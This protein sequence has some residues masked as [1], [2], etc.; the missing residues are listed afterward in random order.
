MPWNESHLD[1]RSDHLDPST[2][3]RDSIRTI[4]ISEADG[5]EAVVG[6]PPARDYELT[7]SFL[8]AKAKG[9]TMQKAQD[10][11]KEHEHVDVPLGYWS[12]GGSAALNPGGRHFDSM[13][14]TVGDLVNVN[15]KIDASQERS[16]PIQVSGCNSECRRLHRLHSAI[17]FPC[18]KILCSLAGGPLAIVNANGTAR[19]D[20]MRPTV[21]D[22]VD[23]TVE[24]AENS[25]PVTR[26]INGKLDLSQPT[27][28]DLS[29]RG[30]GHTSRGLSGDIG[31]HPRR[32]REVSR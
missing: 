1:I 24:A 29:I 14:A 4:A 9:W 5:I 8:F 10:W 30:C 31:L 22:L 15:R 18:S 12:V 21:G 13:K 20:P 28:G 11:F 32:V 26:R 2:C 23:K 17:G 16:N 19:F 25:P 27:V 7:L 3:D 6:K